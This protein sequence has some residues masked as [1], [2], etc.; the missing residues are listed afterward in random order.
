MIIKQGRYEAGAFYIS[1]KSIPEN[2]ALSWKAKGIL[3]YLLSRPPN[4]E[5]STTDL[6]RR[7]SDG[8]DAVRSG[9]AELE[10]AGYIV[11]GR[12]N[13]ASGRFVWVS[14]I[15]DSPIDANKRS[16][17]DDR[18]QP[19][20]ST[21]NPSM[22]NPSMENP[23]GNNNNSN[24]NDLIT[25]GSSQNPT[26]PIAAKGN[27]LFTELFGP[28]SEQRPRRDHTDIDARN[29]GIASAIAGFYED[30]GAAPWVRAGGER[31]TA[32]DGIS[33]LALRRVHWTLTDAG[34]AP[35]NS[36]AGWKTWRP[37]LVAIFQETGGDWSAV[38]RAAR[39]IH[40]KGPYAGK[41]PNWHN[42]ARVAVGAQKATQSA[43]PDDLVA[44][45]VDDFFGGAS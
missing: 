16:R 13:D 5:M 41:P 24:N 37:M 36:D 42:I 23:Q 20:P 21:E 18:K 22:E 11:R 4:W 29:R 12:E 44:V 7:S 43:I 40:Q 19:Q 38:Q 15:Y 17:P 32:R 10:L 27:E 25:S 9:I 31:I 33:E 3:S 8:M 1:P 28:P 2:T 34:I 6:A 14:R 26:P 30:N 39:E 45:S 35:P